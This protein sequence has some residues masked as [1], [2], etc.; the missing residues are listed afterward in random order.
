MRQCSVT[1]AQRL[2]LFHHDPLHSDDF[3][4]SLCGPAAS[5]WEQLGGNPGQIELAAERRELVLGDTAAAAAPLG[6]DKS[7]DPAL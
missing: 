1:A 6:A 2:L 4:D 7:P 3:L 5:G